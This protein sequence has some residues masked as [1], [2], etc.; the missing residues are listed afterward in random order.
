VKFI[1]IP[2][3][4]CEERNKNS[5]NKPTFVQ[6]TEPNDDIIDLTA[7]SPPMVSNNKRHRAVPMRKK[8]I[9]VENDDDDDNDDDDEEDDEDDDDDDDD[10]AVHQL[11]SLTCNVSCQKCSP[12]K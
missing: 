6:M 11:G 8:V 1:R 10:N 9:D 4:K 3:Q 5:H 7:E 2:E 12:M